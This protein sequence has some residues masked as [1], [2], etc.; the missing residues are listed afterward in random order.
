[1]QMR[2]EKGAL[3]CRVCGMPFA[4][5]EQYVVALKETEVE[6]K[7]DRSDVCLR[8]WPR[9]DD[10]SFRCYWRSNFATVKRSPLL[11]PD[12]LWQV[13]HRTIARVGEAESESFLY[14]SALALLRLKQLKLEDERDEDG[15]RFLIFA[16]RRGKERYHVPDIRLDEKGIEVIQDR[17]ADF[18]LDAS[19]GDESD[20]ERDSGSSDENLTVADDLGEDTDVTIADS[21]H[22]DDDGQPRARRITATIPPDDEEEEEHDRG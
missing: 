1:M 14:V 19:G 11:D 10:T 4:D 5:G 17:L 12:L 8:C 20:G 16:L 13:F 3:T 9:Q 15:R 2:I 7:F 21:L 22:D 6:E 18:G